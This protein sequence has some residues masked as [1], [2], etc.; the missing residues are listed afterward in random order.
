[1]DAAELLMEEDEEASVVAAAAVRLR[2]DDPKRLDM[3]VIITQQPEC[4]VTN[5]QLL[6]IEHPAGLVA[7]CSSQ[8]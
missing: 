6:P 3:I 4:N 1:M 8:N 2:L 7:F 5:C